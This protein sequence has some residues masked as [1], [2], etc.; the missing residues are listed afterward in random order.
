MK[1]FCW[2]PYL[3]IQLF[4]EGKRGEKLGVLLDFKQ[5]TIVKSESGSRVKHMNRGRFGKK[6]KSG[7][8]WS[9][10]H[11]WVLAFGNKYYLRVCYDPQFIAT[12]RLRNL[13]LFLNFC[14]NP[15]WV[16]PKTRELTS[17]PFLSKIIFKE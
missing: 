13:R 15:L 1:C 3:H 4:D 8:S 11:I 10:M 16:Q 2:D 9:Y 17:P 7:L 6:S 12:E 14:G 5:M